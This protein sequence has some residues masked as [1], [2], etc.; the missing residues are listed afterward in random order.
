MDADVEELAEALQL[1]QDAIVS[2]APMTAVTSH[3]RLVTVR[4]PAGQQRELV[5]RRFADPASLATHASVLR[6]LSDA[7]F[8]HSTKPVALLQNAACEEAAQGVSAV[9]IAI[10][11]KQ[12]DAV[13]GAAAG[14]HTLQTAPHSVWS[15]D[16]G[17][18]VGAGE[19]PLFRLGFGAEQREAALEPTLSLQRAIGP[20]WLG[21][22]HGQATAANVVLCPDGPR[23]LD[24][25]LAGRGVQLFDLA[26]FLVS[27]GL[28]ADD[29][30]RAACTYAGL[31]SLEREATA[32]LID[33][34]ALLWGLNHLI[35]LPRNEVQLL[36]DDESLGWLRLMAE[37]VSRAIREPAGGH[38]AAAA[39]RAALWPR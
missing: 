20:E 25:S 3:C 4:D 18:L 31:R 27:A 14:L 6:W 17:D 15:Q 36:G 23:F 38:P 21:P 7:G 33:A 34:A 10:G 9:S 28:T 2:V 32:D 29:R 5:I 1:Q 13:A 19:L 26:A 8:G 12:A 24:F 37:R 11:A 16:H 22:V 35:S 30:R 39:L